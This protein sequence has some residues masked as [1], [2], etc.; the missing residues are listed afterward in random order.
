MI[1]SVF[2]RIGVQRKLENN[3]RSLWV[4]V[5]FICQKTSLGAIM[6]RH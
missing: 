3:Q 1:V 5:N 6:K 4:N 2:Q